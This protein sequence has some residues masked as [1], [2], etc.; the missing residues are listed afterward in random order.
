MGNESAHR[1][2]ARPAPSSASSFLFASHPP[3]G[4]LPRE[5]ARTHPTEGERGGA[6]RVDQAARIGHNFANLPAQ[7]QDR[8]GNPPKA[9]TPWGG[10][11]Q[12]PIQLVKFSAEQKAKILAKNRNRNGGFYTCENGACGFQ[13]ALTTYATHRGR[14]LGDGGFHI[15]HIH[16][17]GRGGRALLRNGRV[18]CG[19]CNTSRGSRAN[20]QRFGINKYRGLHRKRVAKNYL[21]IRRN[22]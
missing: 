22:Y 19:T 17:H 12:A 10:G 4:R 8:L 14:R 6:D 21:S 16:H 2:S 13:H 15:D 11:I 18:L 3:A 7:A 1:T 20:A 9:I 5:T